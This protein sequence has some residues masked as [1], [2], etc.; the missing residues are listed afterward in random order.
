MRA[1]GRTEG[2]FLEELLSGSVPASPEL[3]G[4]RGPGGRRHRV[5]GVAPQQAVRDRS[6]PGE[7]DDCTECDSRLHAMLQC[8]RAGRPV[9]AEDEDEYRKA[10]CGQNDCPWE[11]APVVVSRLKRRDFSRR[12]KSSLAAKSCRTAIL[13]GNANRL[14]GGHRRV[15]PEARQPLAYP[16]SAAPKRSPESGMATGPR[17]SN[18]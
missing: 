3:G 5:K 18:K 15:S 17:L 6:K 14:H 8:E 10:A 11:P 12:A 2:I 1:P 9:V 7:R 4:S 16:P 13:S